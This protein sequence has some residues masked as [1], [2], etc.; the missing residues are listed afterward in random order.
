MRPL[1]LAPCRL[2]IEAAQLVAF[3]TDIAKDRIA[4]ITWRA[5]PNLSPVATDS[6]PMYASHILRIEQ[7]HPLARA[8]VL[9]DDDTFLLGKSFAIEHCRASYGIGPSVKLAF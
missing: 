9:D 8:L 3:M 6:Y 5:R 2:T 1:S 4:K 7:V